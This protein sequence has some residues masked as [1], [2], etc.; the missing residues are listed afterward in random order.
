MLVV[1]VEVTAVLVLVLVEVMPLQARVMAQATVLE[2]KALVQ[3]LAAARAIE[4]PRHSDSTPKTQ[5]PKQLS[6]HAKT[7]SPRSS[8][9]APGAAQE[10]VIRRLRTKTMPRSNFDDRLR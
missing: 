7:F 4:L 10:L 3:A 1:L 6:P 9:E 2:T 5:Q 8:P